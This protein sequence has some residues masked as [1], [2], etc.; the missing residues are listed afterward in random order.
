MSTDSV[1]KRYELYDLQDR[2][3]ATIRMFDGVQDAKVTIA[4]SEEN[5]YV[6]SE[7]EDIPATASVFVKMANG[8]SPKPSQVA[9]IQRFLATSIRGVSME[10]VAVIDG[11]GNDVS[12][13]LDDD[14]KNNLDTSEDLSNTAMIKSD[15]EK[16]VERHVAD[17]VLSVFS[18]IYGSGNVR[19]L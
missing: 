10:N 1:Q 7:D 3:A 17:N 5:R 15:M 18:S 12:V 4:L 9:A 19:V 16:M 11:N 2:I 6:L 14:M 13:V 8:G